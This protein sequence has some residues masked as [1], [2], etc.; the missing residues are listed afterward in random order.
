MRQ[1]RGAAWPLAPVCCNEAAK[2]LRINSRGPAAG[3]GGLRAGMP[4]VLA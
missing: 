1:G 3:I 4:R 2:V